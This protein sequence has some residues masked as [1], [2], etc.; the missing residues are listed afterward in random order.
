MSF[1]NF[2]DGGEIAGRRN[3]HAAGA[4][5][6][7]GEQGADGLGTFLDD[8]CFELGGTACGK[9]GFAL[10]VAALVVVIRC[11]GVLDEIKRQAEAVL[12]I[13]EGRH[14]G[15]R[16]GHAVIA[17]PPADDLALFRLSARGLIVPDHLH[18]GVVGFRTR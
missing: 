18:R 6:R 13:G 3:D 7:F 15:R 17:A 5:D 12:C 4:H 1:Q 14:A 2:P 11:G 16:H 10:A 9:F 8:Q